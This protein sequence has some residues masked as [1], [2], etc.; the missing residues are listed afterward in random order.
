MN[1]ECCVFI[2]TVGGLTSEVE[3]PYTKPLHILDK[4]PDSQQLHSN[5]EDTE[6][7]PAGLRTKKPDEEEDVESNAPQM[8]ISEPNYENYHQKVTVPEL[9]LRKLERGKLPLILLFI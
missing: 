4:L 5:S 9:E 3:G 2:M 7:H 6:T 1:V 8:L